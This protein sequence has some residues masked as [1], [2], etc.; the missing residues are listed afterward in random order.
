MAQIEENKRI[1]KELEDQ[2]RQLKSSKS[3]QHMVM[4]PGLF[5]NFYNK[6]WSDDDDVPDNN[7]VHLLLLKINTYL[8]STS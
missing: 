6:W 7:V 5:V 3:S 8:D 2:K 4:P 1:L